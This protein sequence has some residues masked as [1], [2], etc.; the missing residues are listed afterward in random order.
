M[1]EKLSADLE[2]QVTSC[3]DDDIVDVVVE[4]R[5]SEP[6]N[7]S[8]TRQEKIAELKKSFER[9]S[10]GVVKQV[11]DSGGTVLDRAWINQTLRARMPAQ[12]VRKL[13]ELDDVELVDL[14]REIS[15]DDA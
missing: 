4:L 10:V 9:I 6:P 3:G 15:L 13:S 8:G 7:A 1:A 12:A 14:P 11:E 2:G 5:K